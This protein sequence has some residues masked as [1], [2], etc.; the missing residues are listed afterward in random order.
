MEINDESLYDRYLKEHDED[1][2]RILIERFREKLTL[3]IYGKIYDMDEAEDIM[4]DCFAVVAMG[5]SIFHR[6]SSFKTWLFSIGHN[7][8]KMYLRSKREQ[9]PIDEVGDIKA[10][11]DERPEEEILKSEENARLYEAMEKI[12]PDKREL[13]HLLYFEDM[14][15]E[16]VAGVIGKTKKQ[17]YRMMEHAREA[18]KKVMENA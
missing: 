11:D 1:A 4:M 9:V 7:K 13:L 3:F 6:R 17:T 5:R 12:S 8:A 10:P 2:L 15:Y 16:E 14:D 18:L